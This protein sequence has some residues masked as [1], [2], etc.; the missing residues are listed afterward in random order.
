MNLKSRRLAPEFANLLGLIVALGVTM[1]YFRQQVPTFFSANNLELL[2][3]QTAIVAAASLGMTVIIISGG[4]DL[5]V[6]SV[7][8]LVTV[9]VA[10]MVQGGSSPWLAFSGGVLAAILAGAFNG[11]LVATLRIAPFLATLG[12]FLIARGIAKGMAHNQKIDAPLTWMNDLLS[13][14]PANERWKLLPP[15]VW[16]TI[17]LAVGLAVLLKTTVFGRR[18]F[19]VGVNEKAAH[20]NG[21]NVSVTKICVY[22]LGGLFVG[23]AGVL[24]F[25]RLS[26]GDPTV[27]IGMELDV[28]TAVVIGGAS[29]SGGVGSV[30][31]TLLGAVLM[32]VVRMGCSQM[33]LDNW[34]REIATGAIIVV[35][36]AI[37]RLRVGRRQ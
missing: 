35:A 15:G 2:A 18:V 36:I 23:F 22:A 21:I 11:L 34:V 7:I 6:G 14:L 13:V 30:G 29:L 37:D 33:G 16:I 20:L 32:S 26:V 5:S 9:V 31:G 25:A 27:A 28:I 19:A 3:R 1:L 4:I 10:A 8:A 24:Q 17:L 12:M